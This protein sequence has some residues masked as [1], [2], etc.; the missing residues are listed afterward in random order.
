MHSELA[1]G[2]DRRCAAM[3]STAAF[4]AAGLTMMKLFIDAVVLIELTGLDILTGLTSRPA[5]ACGVAAL[6]ALTIAVSSRPKLGNYRAVPIV[7]SLVMLMAMLATAHG[8]A[9][10]DDRLLLTVFTA[11]HLLGVAGWIGGIPYLLLILR[12]PGARASFREIGLRFS[13]LSILC[14][15]LIAFSGFGM[16]AKYIGA[17]EAVFGTA[18]G[19][20]V[21]TKLALLAGLLLLGAGNFAAVRKH[22]EG[23]SDRF[24]RLR[25]FGEAEIGIGIAVL[26]CAASLTSMPPAADIPGDRVP[27]SEIAERL[28]PRWPSFD[29]PDMYSLAV[30]A[31]QAERAER[32]ALAGIAAPPAYV[33]GVGIPPPRSAAKIAR[34]EYNHHLAGLFVLV[35]GLLAIAERSGRAAWARN[36]PLLFI[37]LALAMF[38]LS[39]VEAWPRSH[40]SFLDSLRDP[41]VLQ[42]RLVFTLVAL[43]GIFE[44]FVRTGRAKSQWM[45]L[46]LPLLGAIGSVVLLTHTHQIVGIK[47]QLLQEMTHA[48]LAIL[49]LAASWSRWIEIRLPTN[50][51]RWAGAVWPVCFLLVGVL[52]LSY[53]ET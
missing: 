7:A 43:F 51:G 8:A 3:L 6:A 30:P 17:F 35:I 46:V 29:S 48:P 33:S 25:R 42:H 21:S 32:P 4:M 38:Y 13:K 5:I 28:I 49:G 45:A 11:M 41:E 52:L 36:W 23:D 44:W 31:L 53:R 9:R 27:W 40:G 14:V 24:L 26:F 19:L 10:P 20:M 2:A 22:R 15:G 50:A 1:T 47:D 34:S 37:G 39:D 12:D 18:Y 16:S